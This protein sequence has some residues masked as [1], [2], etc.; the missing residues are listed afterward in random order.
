MAPFSETENPLRMNSVNELVINPFADEDNKDQVAQ[1]LKPDI[2]LQ[3][4]KYEEL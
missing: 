4:L 3:S 1:E 2:K